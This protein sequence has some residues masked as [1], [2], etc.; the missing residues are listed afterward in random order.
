MRGGVQSIHD[1]DKFPIGYGNKS[2]AFYR[3]QSSLVFITFLQSPSSINLECFKWNSSAF[4]IIFPIEFSTNA[5][6][7][8]AIHS[9]CIYIFAYKNVIANDFNLYFTLDLI[10]FCILTRRYS[11][12]C[13]FFSLSLHAIQC[14]DWLESWQCN[15]IFNLPLLD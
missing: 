3:L 12:V 2:K 14:A 4:D 5:S 8:I 10:C 7:I 15:R 13:L 9:D 6:N 1:N 11:C